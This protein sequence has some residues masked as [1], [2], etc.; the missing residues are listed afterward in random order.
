MSKY[1]VYTYQFAPLQTAPNH[2]FGDD[3]LLTPQQAMDHKQE[4]FGKLLSQEN[5]SFSYIAVR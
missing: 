1:I 3:D 5:L 4:I 2:L